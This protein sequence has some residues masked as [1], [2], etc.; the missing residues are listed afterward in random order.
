MTSADTYPSGGSDPASLREI[1]SYDLERYP[2]PASVRELFGGAGLAQLHEHFPKSGQ[3][4]GD[5]DT[6]AHEVFYR[7]YE[8]IAGLYE[9]FLRDVIGP[10]YGEDLCVQRVPTFRVHYPGAVAVREYHRDSDYHHDPATI[11]FWLPLTP[12][13]GTNTIW[14]ESAPD[15]AD[16]APVELVPGQVL[17]F[18]AVRLTHGNQSNDTPATRVSFDFRVLPLRRYRDSGLSTVTS[19]R[20]LRLDDYYA[21]LTADGELRYPVGN[22]V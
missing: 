18:D 14:I 22:R 10:R 20:R 2:F 13:F 6:P 19:G 8:R 12:A 4:T 1:L 17:R 5:Q 21:L 3:A 7:G 11:N 15:S 9:Q 16:F